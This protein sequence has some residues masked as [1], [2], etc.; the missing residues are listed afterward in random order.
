MHSPAGIETWEELYRTIRTPV[1]PDTVVGFNINLDRILPVT[2]GL[3]DSAVLKNRDLIRLRTRLLRSMKYCTAEEWFVKSR[4]QYR[5]FSYAFSSTGRLVIGGQAGIA[6]LH[7]AG[8]GM[9]RVVCA[10]PQRSPEVSLLLTR[11]G[12]TEPD[13]AAGRIPDEEKTHLVF[14]YAPGLIPTA[15]GITCRHNRFIVS[16]VHE[17]ASVLIPEPLMEYFL[18]SIESCTRG[19]FSGYQYL[20]TRRDFMT[21]AD[22]LARMKDRN[23]SLRVHIEW[24]SVTDVK[25]S[26]QCARYILPGADSFG[27]NVQELV[28]FLSHIG[29]PIREGREEGNIRPVQVIEGALCLCR[30]LGLKRLH[31]HT[32]GYYVQVVND[33]GNDPAV[34]RNALLYAA[35]E[36]AKAAR[37][38]NTVV[39]SDGLKAV[40]LAAG[41]FR[42][43]SPGIFRVGSCTVLLVPTL[44]A[45]NITKTSG[46]GDILSSTAFVADIV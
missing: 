33:T 21:A 5:R 43:E 31:V 15:P 1:L 26:R 25:I 4:D 8:I 10:S 12:V 44:V 19:F 28:C 11:A 13:L 3:L 46:L 42:Q 9:G 35:Q 24:V 41:V 7:L 6:A 18:S 45:M 22:Q 30:E 29:L 14:E 34:S 38:T 16:P 32:Y 17:P 27:L 23:T 37:G 39:S 20:R 36:T 40:D 2:R